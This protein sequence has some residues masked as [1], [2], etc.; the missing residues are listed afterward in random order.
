M[1]HSDPILITGITPQGIQWA[2]G[3]I[4]PN[5]LHMA[6]IARIGNKGGPFLVG[7]GTTILVERGGILFMRMNDE[8]TFNNIGSFE[9]HITNVLRT[10]VVGVTELSSAAATAAAGQP[11]ADSATATVPASSEVGR[12]LAK[13]F[14]II[15]GVSHYRH[16]GKWQ[17]ENLRYAARDADALATHL[18]SDAGGRFD[19]VELL[20]DAQATRQNL[21][22]A[23][24]EKLRGV[25]PDDF[26]VIFWSGH[27]SPDPHDPG[28]LYLITHD[29]DPEH[30]AATAYPM[31]TFK[32]DIAKLKARRV[33]VLADTCHSAGISDP[34]IGLRGVEENKIVD[35]LRGIG[36][37]GPATGPAGPMRMIFTSCET[38]EKSRE[39]ANLGG[40]HGVFTWFLLQSLKGEADKPTSGGDGNGTVTL[41]E[42]IEYTRDQVKR[43]T[44]N[45]QHPDTAG[46]FD[47]N[48]TMGVVR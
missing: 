44:G 9:V 5:W 2:G 40:G 23:I 47:R 6:L 24:R 16:R 32:A 48:L 25:Q 3:T 7:T 39:S 34:A 43:F 29:T 37:S 14:A 19:R 13:R 41:G 12:I 15:I 38:G 28:S 4:Y 45:Q 10:P 18:R 31:D 42:L 1:V 8:G 36:V 35:G 11:A 30:M 22:I 26:V 46:R 27:G 17:L 33:L 20:T 21:M